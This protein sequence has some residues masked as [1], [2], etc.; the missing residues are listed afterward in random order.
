MSKSNKS[1]V[2]ERPAVSC[3]DGLEPQR[4]RLLNLTIMR[5]VIDAD[6]DDGS[7]VEF[8]SFSEALQGLQRVNDLK[9]LNPKHAN[10][11]I[12]IYKLERP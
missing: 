4:F 2:A 11:E 9:R 8:E 1:V 5:D 3:T 12:T 10:D 7:P 6:S